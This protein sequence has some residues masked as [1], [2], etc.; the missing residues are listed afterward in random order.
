MPDDAL[1]HVLLPPALPAPFQGAL[2]AGPYNFE[3]SDEE[4]LRLTTWNSAAGATVRI[5]GRIKRPTGE[6]GDI[7]ETQIP[8]TDRSAKITD[9]PLGRGY[10]LNVTVYVSAGSPKISQTFVRLQLIRGSSGATMPLGTLV[11]DTVTASLDVA[12]PGSPLRTSLE[13]D[14]YLYTFTGADPAAGTEIAESV[15]TGARWELIAARFTLNTSATVANRIP[16][17]RIVTATQTPGI[18]FA[19]NAQA[20]SA[21]VKYNFG[22]GMPA[23]AVNAA[24]ECSV[25][26]P[27]GLGALAASSVQSFTSALQAGDNWDAPIITVREWL[28]AQ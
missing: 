13:T 14:G 28:E 9:L 23:S 26:F 3:C 17:L 6:I 25:P 12:W 2:T 10:L 8:N 24:G 20:N 16:G 11:Q 27:I 1:S 22:A 19:A 5:V 7:D 18:Y 15:P 21:G 4:K